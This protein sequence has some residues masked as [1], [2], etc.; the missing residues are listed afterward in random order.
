MENQE[1]AEHFHTVF[2]IVLLQCFHIALSLMFFKSIFLPL[3]II[4]N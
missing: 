3:F 4:L 1:I 2:S